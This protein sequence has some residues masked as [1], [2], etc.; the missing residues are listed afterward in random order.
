LRFDLPILLPFPLLLLL[1]ESTI[2]E[3][4]SIPEEVYKGTANQL[5]DF[6]ARALV[7]F[8]TKTEAAQVCGCE[9]EGGWVESKE[10]WVCVGRGLGCC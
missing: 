7:G 1:Q 9:C 5:F 4:V 3:Q 10:E 2:M 6:M 8:I